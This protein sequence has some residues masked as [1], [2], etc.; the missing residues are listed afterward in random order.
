MNIEIKY[1]NKK[2]LLE[3]DKRQ[4]ILSNGYKKTKTG[5]FRIDPKYYHDLDKALL[6]LLD[7]TIKNSDA[8]TLEKL[9]EELRYIRK[10]IFNKTSLI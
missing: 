5:E 2:Y 4:Y 6:G 10:V 1:R 9:Y 7:R 8:D 3:S